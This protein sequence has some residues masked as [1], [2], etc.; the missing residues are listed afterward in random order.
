MDKALEERIGMLEKRIREIDDREAILKLKYTYCNIN[1]GGHNGIATHHD[2][3]GLVNMFLPDGVWD[4]APF[5][6]KAVGQAQIREMFTEW[7]AIPFVIHHVM[8]PIIEIDG[9]TAHGDYHG[10]ITSVMPPN[11]Q[12]FW[13]LGKYEEDYVRTPE[14]WKIKLLRWVSAAITPFEEGW[15]KTQYGNLW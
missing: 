9:D 14:G 11:N 15:G 1:D 3:D 5:I 8:N 4:G 2:I 7:K 6:P 13:L 12:A 10:I